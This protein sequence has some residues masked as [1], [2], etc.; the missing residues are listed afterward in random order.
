VRFLEGKKIA[1]RSLFGSNMVRLPAY[2]EAPH[3]MIG[4]LENSDFAT[5]QGGR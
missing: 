1:T 5:N 3:R 4:K 2:A